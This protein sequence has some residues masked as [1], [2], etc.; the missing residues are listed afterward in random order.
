LV[1]KAEVLEKYSS[2][3]TGSK[4][5]NHYLSYARD[6][7]DHSDG[8]NKEFVTKYI[9]RLR[10][11]KKSPGTRNFAFRVIRRLFIVNGLD[12]PFLRGQA[13]QIGQRD[14]YKHKFETGQ[15]LFD[16]WVSR[17]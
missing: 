11:H 14:E 8:L 6:F 1:S 10:R 5:R 9:E 4:N 17:K 15:E 7:L 16:W 2:N 3:L 13:P 12:W